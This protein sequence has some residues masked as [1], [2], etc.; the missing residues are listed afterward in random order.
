[1]STAASS[2]SAGTARVSSPISAAL[3]ASNTSPVRK[4][5]AAARGSSLR[6]TGTEIIAGTTPS[7]TS[8]NAKEA[9][10]GAIAKSHAATRPSPPARAVPFRRQMTGF[11][12]SQ[13]SARISGNDAVTGASPTP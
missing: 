3:A 4:Y 6:S 2:S 7:R 9:V 8:V 12:L 11:G 13:I 5:S 10:T 1:M